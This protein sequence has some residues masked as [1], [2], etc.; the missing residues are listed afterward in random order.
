MSQSSEQLKRVNAAL[1]LRE[2]PDYPAAKE[3]LQKAL[4]LAQNDASIRLLLG[5]TFMDLDQLEEAENHLRIAIELQPDL[6]EARQAFAIVLVQN[7]KYTE[8]L[9]LLQLLT[10]S[11]PANLA[12]L[13]A[14]AVSYHQLGRIPEAVETVRKMIFLKPEDPRYQV[15]LT[16]LLINYPDMKEAEAII[17]QIIE[18]APTSQTWT[19]YAILLLRQ[20]NL[21]AAEEKFR[22]ALDLDRENISGWKNL[23]E[24]QSQQKKWDQVFQTIEDGLE[25]FD[26]SIDLLSKKAVALAWTDRTPEVFEIFDQITAH[27]SDKQISEFLDICENIGVDLFRQGK[28]EASAYLY[29]YI[30]NYKPDRS[31]SLNNLA[32]ILI[33]LRSWQPARE[34]LER[35]SAA[36]YEQG[37]TLKTNQGYIELQVGDYSSALASFLAA[38]QAAQDNNRSI[39]HIAYPWTDGLYHSP[40]DD[41]PTRFV[42]E[43]V[44]IHANLATTYF[45][46]GD[47]PLAFQHAD[48][49]VE[50]DPTESIGYRILGCLH[51]LTSEPT[52]ASQSWARAL[53]SITSPAEKEIVNDWLVEL[54]HRTN[55]ITNS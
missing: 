5:L 28:S 55:N 35:A 42:L 32:F 1:T 48:A 18:I 19:L 26:H 38:L 23:I 29:Q 13:Q 14:L 52:A 4:S 30:L 40:T 41:F 54:S 24:V 36:G 27:G 33:S 9:P 7:K 21:S 44:S 47:A 53:E 20:K 45:L 22:T 16:V 11:E 17:R 3:Q 46:L 8:A 39:L 10:E 49:A 34:M 50:I 15:H 2:I 31:R 43:R 6:Q 25:Y 12:V 37:A 51:F